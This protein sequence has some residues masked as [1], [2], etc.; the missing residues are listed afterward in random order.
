MLRRS[1]FLI[2]TIVFWVNVPTWSQDQSIAKNEPN[3]MTL[4]IDLGAGFFQHVKM[5]LMNFKQ[6]VVATSDNIIPTNI[7][8][9]FSYYL[10]PTVAVRFSSGYGFSVQKDKGNIDYGKIDSMNAKLAD[11]S[12]FS[13]AG[14]P[15]ET[16][17]IFQKPIDTQEN[18]LFHIGIGVGYYSYNYK[19][20]GK[21]KESNS[22]LN[23]IRWKEEYRTP[24]TTL[25]GWAQFFVLGLNINLNQNMAASFEVSKIGLS[26]MRLV[27]DIIKQEVYDREITNELM[28]GYRQHDYKTKGG[29]EDIAISLGIYWKL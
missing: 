13:M 16:A 27:T 2:L 25:S 8:A 15:L 19:A 26:S 23:K 6:E 24:E 28:Y 11:E 18:I 22:E 12:I 10:T 9:N 3:K 20:E 17:L 1:I 21:F 4:G 14:F 5:N 29:F 7:R